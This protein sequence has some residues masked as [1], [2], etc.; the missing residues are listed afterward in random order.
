MKPTEEQLIIACQKKDSRAFQSIYELYASKMMGIC[1]RYM[2]NRYEAEDV[3]QESFIKVYL[4]IGRFRFDGSFE[5]W[6]RR[7]VVNVALNK[8]RDDTKKE[9]DLPGDDMLDIINDTNTYADNQYNY[10]MEDMLSAIQRLSSMNRIV[11]NLA[12]IEGYT[13]QEIA[14]KLELS[15]HTI[16]ATLS[17][18]KTILRTNLERKKNKC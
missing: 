8:L 9:C 15:E 4:N 10:T 1:L 17:R 16:R 13:T 14:E 5:G 11:F 18:A 7:I 12:E 6:I 3:L 2:H